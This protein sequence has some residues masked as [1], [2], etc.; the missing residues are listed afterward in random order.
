MGARTSRRVRRLEGAVEMGRGDHHTTT[1]RCTACSYEGHG[2]SHRHHHRPVTDDSGGGDGGD[3][4]D[5]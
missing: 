5:A 1:T 3:G 4:G 2:K